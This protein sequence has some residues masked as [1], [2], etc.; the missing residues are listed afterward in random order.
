MMRLFLQG[1]AADPSQ[2][3]LLAQEFLAD[4]FQPLPVATP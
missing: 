1:R 3:P 2:T 4:K